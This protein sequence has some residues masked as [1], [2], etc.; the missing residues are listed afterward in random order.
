MGK[1]SIVAIAKEP[2]VQESVTRVFDLMGGVTKLIEKGSTVVL[3]PNAGHVAD[4]HS[5]VVTSP[6]MVQAVVREV[7]K[8]EP[9]R[10]IIAEA[11]AIGCDTIECFKACELDRVA[12][13]EGVEL[14]DIKREKDLINIPVRGYKSNISHVKLP[15]WLVEAEHI[16]NLPILKAHASMMFSCAL[17]N[18]KG[19]V[20]D[21]VHL[22]MHSQNLTMAMMDVWYAVRA[23]IN[24]VDAIYA[25]GGYSPHEPVPEYIGCILGSKD[26][27]AVDRICCYL[28]GI[29]PKAV[30]YFEAAEEAGF[31]TFRD[32]DIEVIGERWQDHK[33][34]LWVPYLMGMDS[35]PE[36]DIYYE[37][38]CSSCQALLALNMGTMKANGMYEKNTDM[39]I[40]VGRKTPEQM[41]EICAKYPPDK[42]ILHGNCLKR[43]MREGKG[44]FVEGC[45]PA[46]GGLKNAVAFKKTITDDTATKEDFEAIMALKEA[47]K[48]IWHEYVMK[49]AER[50]KAEKAA[51]AAAEKEAAAK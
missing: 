37:N 45:P 9:K 50:Y 48:P 4:P 42:L 46:E 34:D 14:I 43:Y 28:A 11:A 22:D 13:E 16:I 1:K 27:V 7:K 25:A 33:I 3:K 36:Y 31:G 6:E 35:W 12:E 21:R 8:A 26:P 2:S 38:A 24:I 47:D 15:R 49:E 32:E 17:K 30:S 41:A 23:D 19:V 44:I 40:V 10:I 20:Q 29:N 5:A 39:A 51:K 18:I